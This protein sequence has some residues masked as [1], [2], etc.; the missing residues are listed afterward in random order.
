MRFCLC[1]KA[2]RLSGGHSRRQNQTP[3]MVHHRAPR[4]FTQSVPGEGE[5]KR[6]ETPSSRPVRHPLSSPICI[7]RQPYPGNVGRGF[8]WS[9]NGN[10]QMERVCQRRRSRAASRSRLQQRALCHCG[11]EKELQDTPSGADIDLIE[12]GEEEIS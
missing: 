9:G 4:Q 11:R 8:M 6:H 1:S 7:S 10:L 12:V 2:R 3:A 5:I